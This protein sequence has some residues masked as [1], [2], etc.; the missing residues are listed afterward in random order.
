MN[1]QD[2][3]RHDPA[4]VSLCE[5]YLQEDTDA[6]RLLNKIMNLVADFALI[7]E[8]SADNDEFDYAAEIEELVWAAKNLNNELERNDLLSM[9]DYATQL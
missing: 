2:F 5:A 7:D 6:L 9:S 4:V 1:E 3:N 8:L